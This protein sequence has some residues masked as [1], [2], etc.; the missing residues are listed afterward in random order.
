M[1]VRKNLKNLLLT[2][3]ALGVL[4]TPAFAQRTSVDY[5]VEQASPK[6]NELM[7]QRDNFSTSEREIRRETR[8]RP[9]IQI[10]IEPKRKLESH[11]YGRQPFNNKQSRDSR[12]DHNKKKKQDR[13]DR[14][15]HEKDFRY[16]SCCNDSRNDH[17]RNVPYYD[18]VYSNLLIREKLDYQLIRQFV[19]LENCLS[20]VGN[21][22]SK[23]QAMGINDINKGNV[24]MDLAETYLQMG[25]IDSSYYQ[26]EFSARR[27]FQNALDELE[28]AERNYGNNYQDYQYLIEGKKSRVRGRINQLN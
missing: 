25:E 13:F 5:C 26:D 22:Y 6:I 18:R 28:T 14:H 4:A 12:H 23:V 17:R 7:W 3:V 15:N 21:Q 2:G 16:E 27:N 24:N 8:T 11:E 20:N 1:N 10:I 19:S 9:R